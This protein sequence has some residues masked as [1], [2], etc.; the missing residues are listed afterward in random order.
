M[1]IFAERRGG[2]RPF[3]E[4]SKLP[5]L[6]SF[7]YKAD[8]IGHAHIQNKE[9]KRADASLLQLPPILMDPS[10][11][12]LFRWVEGERATSAKS[13]PARKKKK[14]PDK[15]PKPSKKK[16]NSKPTSDDLKSLDDKRSQRF[17]RLESMLLPKSFAVLVEPV[18]KPATVVTSD[19]PFLIQEP[20]P[21]RCV[22]VLPLK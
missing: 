2:R 18:K 10:E 9:E 22:P 14:R 20:V 6:Q 8:P 15:S 16:L 5:Y 1:A 4:V 12:T 3:C 7:H 13:T 21:A 19:Q 17:A 11:V